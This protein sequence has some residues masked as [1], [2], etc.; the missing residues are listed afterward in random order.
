MAIIPLQL[1]RVS[2]ALTMG[3]AQR[4]ITRTQQSLLEVQNQLTSG[5]RINV[6]SDDPVG[7]SAAAQLRRVLELNDG[8]ATNLQNAST[9]LS[10][11][12]TALGDLTDQLQNA[13]SIAQANVGDTVTADARS[14]AAAMVDSIYNQVLNLANQQFEGTYVF[15]GQRADQQPFVSDMGGIRFTGSDTVLQNVYEP[16]TK[17]PFMVNGNDV[18]GALSGRVKGSVDLTPS[19]T[20]S[21]RLADLRGATGQGVRPGSIV[22]SDGTTSKA[23]DLSHADTV[24]DVV[25]AINAAGVGG[26]TASIA[27]GGTGLLLSAGA[28]DNITVTESGGTTAADLGILTPVGG[29]AGVNVTGQPLSPRVTPLT[30][31][32]NLRNGSGINTAAGLVITNGAKTVTVSLAGVTT[33]EGLLNA[34]NGSGVGAL[35]RINSDG[36]GIDVLNSVQGTSLT[37]GENGGTTAADLGIRSMTPQTALSELNGGQGVRTSANGADIQVTRRNGTTFQ[38]DLSNLNTIQD[39]INAINAADGG[40]GLTASFAASG[41]GIVLTDTTGG[42]GTLRVENLNFSKAADD[43]GIAGTASGAVMNGKDVNGVAANGIFANLA[44]LRDALIHNDTGAITAAAEAIQSDQ[45]RVVRTRARVGAAVKDFESRQQR[46]QDQNVA[47][48]SLLSSIEDVDYNE[49]VTRF[50]TLQTALQANLQTTGKLLNL[51]LL[52]FLG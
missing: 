47:T 31:L 32:A 29:G 1:A 8:Y 37:I 33:V 43:L 42:A 49:A 7:A 44:K 51:S 35:A 15:G 45:N 36:T 34:I 2:N 16:G 46:L 21:T 30:N 13:Y 4:S 26:I 24:Q 27:P 41:N 17:L 6:P 39:V 20:L 10:T 25:N 48:K 50:Q 12:D 9:Q 22:L 23:V 38:V 40:G 3:L 11:V 5:K 28:G 19:V 52:D 18:F 14:A